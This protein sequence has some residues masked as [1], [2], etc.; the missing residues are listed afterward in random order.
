MTKTLTAALSAL[1]ILAP[2]A[3]LAGDA[4]ASFQTVAAKQ[5]VAADLERLIIS[6]VSPGV[7]MLRTGDTMAVCRIEQEE[8]AQEAPAELVFGSEEGTAVGHC[9]ALKQ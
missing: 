5:N 9:W 7:I 4:A 6:Y 2:S 8:G 1:A 3:I